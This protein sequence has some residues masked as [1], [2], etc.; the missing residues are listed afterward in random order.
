[1]WIV[2]VALN[3]P[4]TFVVLALLIL[5][6]SPLVILRTPTDIFPNIAIPVVS[7][8]WNY[9]G[10][11]P[12]EMADRIVTITERSITTTVNDIEHMES[13]SYNGVGVIKLFFRPSVTIATALAQVTAICQTQLRQLPPG[14]TAPL[15][16]SY[17]ASTVPVLQVGLSSTRLSEQQLFD[18]GANV[19]RT[20]LATVQGAAVPWPYG[21]KMR[22]VS[23][24]ID[25]AAM[26]AKGLSPTDV[27]NAVNAENLILPSGT[28]KLGPL[29]YQV[30]M[31]GSTE[32]INELN[33]LP[34]KT[35]NGATIYVR[36]V[37]HV[38]DGFSPQTN[39][40]RQDGSRSA[41][42]SVY[43]T[44]S[45]STLAIVH[46]VRT[47]LS[48]MAAGLPPELKITPLFDQSIF[49]RAAI[50]GVIREALTAACLTA[51]MILL[52]LG[53]WR[54]ALAVLC[55]APAPDFRVAADLLPKDTPPSRPVCRPMCWNAVPTL[56]GKS[57]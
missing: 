51:A 5:L 17:S 32:T 25:S 56:R 36:D 40:V 15:I 16:L 4:Y 3:R 44:G 50:Q 45:A 18:L 38:R 7:V 11:A 33:N 29:E 2:R 52:F 53:N 10:F 41:L 6:V 47:A 26:Q 27:V 22:L 19:I 57:A 55:G 12:E 14:T 8:I 54:N 39:I 24:D 42:L 34:V 31:N 46:D 48:A 9:D 30:E 28:A 49:V 23:I 37:A 20:Q 13:Q 1:M 35:V 43:K 21:G